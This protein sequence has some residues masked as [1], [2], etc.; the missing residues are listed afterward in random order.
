M[1]APMVMPPERHTIECDLAAVLAAA[2]VPAGPIRAAMTAAHARARRSTGSSSGERRRRRQ[3]GPRRRRRRRRRPW[4]SSREA[5]A[6]GPHSRASSLRLEAPPPAPR[7]PRR[8]I[9]SIQVARLPPPRAQPRPRSD[10]RAPYLERSSLRGRASREEQRS[11]SYGEGALVLAVPQLLAGF[12]KR[13]E[14]PRLRRGLRGRASTARG[15]RRIFRRRASRPRA[16]QRDARRRGVDG[17]EAYRAAPSLAA[18]SFRLSA[19]IATGDG[20]GRG[21]R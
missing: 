11:S 2:G 7:S 18:A 17:A 21:P 8:G 12:T 13:R 10:P 6:D 1:P 15:S 4:Y 14:G 16:A 20:A 19:P 9:T 3:G 5:S